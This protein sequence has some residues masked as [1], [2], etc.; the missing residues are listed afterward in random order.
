MVDY[1][2]W[3]HIEV[4]DDEDDTHPNIDTP[5]LFRWRHQ[6]RVDR[7]DKQETERAT[8]DAKLAKNREQMQKL[9]KEMAS[10]GDGKKKELKAKKVALKKEKESLEG[11]DSKLKKDERLTPWNVDT[12]SQPGFEKSVINKTP[13]PAPQPESEDAWVDGYSNFV[14]KNMKE[15]KQFAMFSR[16][17][18]SE[19]FLKDHNYLVCDHGANFLSIWCV[20]LCVEEKR[21][22]MERVS[23][24]VI[25]LQYILQLAKS[26]NADPRGC[27]GPFYS[28]FKVADKE[29]QAAYEDEVRSF[30][31]RVE[32]RAQARLEAAV[33]EHEEEERQKRLGPGGLDPVDVFE[34]LPAVLQKCF[35]EKDIAGLQVAMSSLPKEEAAHHL[36]RCIDSGM[37]VPGGG[38][39]AEGGE[40]EEE[41]YDEVGP[42]EGDENQDGASA[43]AAVSDG[44]EG[45]AAAAEAAGNSE[46]GTSAAA[47]AAG[48]SEEAAATAATE[49]SS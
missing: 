39:A 5:S 41:T 24:Q 46:E 9:D 47:E 20:D 34:T 14:K 40:E 15:M 7:M 27:T 6:A 31:E 33:K 32:G 42:A 23:R 17:E 21:S 11:E 37:W 43:A 29:Y 48:N 2:K 12:L 44:N 16:H 49:A 10:A 38:D 45:G 19:R 28:K 25:V 3:N 18:D 13:E 26:L 1:S 22:L 4:S 30:I 8:M 35:E 36:K